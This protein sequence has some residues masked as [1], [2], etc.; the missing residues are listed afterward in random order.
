[1]CIQVGEGQREGDKESEAVSTEPNLGLKLTN[2][3]SWLEPK[4]ERLNQRSRPSSLRIVLFLSE[5]MAV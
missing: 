1:M 5:R 3:E 4:S 2:H